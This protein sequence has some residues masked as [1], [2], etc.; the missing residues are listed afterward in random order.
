VN[1][2]IKDVL[3]QKV[4]KMIKSDQNN[5]NTYREGNTWYAEKGS[6]KESDRIRVD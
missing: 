5:K 1:P 6:V 3:E 4:N 2:K